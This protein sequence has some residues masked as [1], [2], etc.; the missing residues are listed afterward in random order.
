[1]LYVTGMFKR[2]GACCMWLGCLREVVRGVCDWD[3]SVTQNVLQLFA[4]WTIKS[5][6][7]YILHIISSTEP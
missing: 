2:S 6:N 4:A 3:I 5:L 7:D 1:V